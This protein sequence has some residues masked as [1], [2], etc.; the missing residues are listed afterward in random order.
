[1]KFRSLFL[2][3]APDADMEKHQSKIE[4]EKYVLYVNLAQNQQ[5]ALD[6]AKKYARDKGIHSM[7]LCPGFDH[8]DVAQISDAVGNDVGV[9]VARGD[10]PSSR[11]AKEAMEEADW[12][13]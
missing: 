11:T 4:T 7:I 13:D 3:I 12:F 6:V 1:M 9:T 5:E 2:A 8:E 10:S